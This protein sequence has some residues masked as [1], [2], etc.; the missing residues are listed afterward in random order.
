MLMARGRD[1]DCDRARDLL[2]S[3][4]STAEALGMTRLSAAC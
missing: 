3:A 1:E 2:A 4:H